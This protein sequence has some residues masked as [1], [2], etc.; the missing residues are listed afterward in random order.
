[1]WGGAASPTGA[2][3]PRWAPGYPGN[4]SRRGLTT[5]PA[6]TSPVRLLDRPS[7]VGRRLEGTHP[8]LDPLD[9]HLHRKREQLRLGGEVVAQRTR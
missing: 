1:M 9:H 4:Q 2:R 8:S 6:F 7:R 5:A 3:A